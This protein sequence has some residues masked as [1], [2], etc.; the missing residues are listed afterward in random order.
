[1]HVPRVQPSR[2]A[3]GGGMGAEEAW[4]PRNPHFPMRTNLALA[5]THKT[6][7]WP[8]GFRCNHITPNQPRNPV[9]PVFL[10]TRCSKMA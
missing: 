6:H 1:M 4:I 3:S 9:V 5:E 8:Y 2:P 7:S 10:S